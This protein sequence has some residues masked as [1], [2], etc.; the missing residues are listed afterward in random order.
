[1]ALEYYQMFLV[2]ITLHSIIL[3]A[4]SVLLQRSKEYS[5]PQILW[6]LT[7]ADLIFFPAGLLIA[8]Y[9]QPV[10]SMLSALADIVYSVI[11]AFVFGIEIPGFVLLSKF[12]DKL[13]ERLKLVRKELISISYSFDNVAKL[14]SLAKNNEEML[15]AAQLDELVNDFI[16]SCERM[17]NLDKTFWGMVLG[18]VTTSIKAFA[19][20]SKHPFPKLVD[21]L[22]LAGL[23]FLLAQ[24]LKLLG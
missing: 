7:M 14:K 21:I 12:D 20:R 8:S 11:G 9:L 13:V 18:E 17:R 19:E 5:R 24:F 23:S 16:S 1:M 15:Q 3:G 4:V 22:S 10:V 2:A 6:K